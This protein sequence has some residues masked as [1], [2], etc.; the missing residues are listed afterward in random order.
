[1]RLPRLDPIDSGL[2][3]TIA[4]VTIL[5]L[6]ALGVARLLLELLR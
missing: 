4:R 5:T 1:M 2:I 3:S 6:I